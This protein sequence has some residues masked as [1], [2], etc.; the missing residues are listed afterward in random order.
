MSVSLRAPDEFKKMPW[1]N[2]LGETI[3]LARQDADT[4]AG[5]FWRISRASVAAC[6]P[7]SEFPGVDRELL[8]LSGAGLTLDL[9]HDGQR[10]INQRYQSIRFPG[11]VPA[12]CRLIDGPCE[13][14]NIMVTRGLG[15][16]TV[17]RHDLHARTTT[18]RF[19]I[20]YALEGD[21]SLNLVDEGYPL[22]TGC[23][24]VLTDEPGAVFLT[25]SGMLL[26]VDIQ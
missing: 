21:W 19:T 6:G 14:L 18:A 16:A 5:F 22:G 10:T 3:E 11:D 2:G 26:Q 23:L 4:P 15:S 13:D 24:A 7:F 25:G 20:F 8:L 9:A 12:H 17:T 1:R